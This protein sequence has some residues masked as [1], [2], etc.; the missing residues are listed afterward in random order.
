MP[1]TP[2]IDQTGVLPGTYVRLMVD[3]AREGVIVKPT[4]S[5]PQP[6]QDAGTCWFKQFELYRTPSLSLNDNDAGA[7]V[8]AA[9]KLTEF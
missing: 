8:T 7:Y 9:D 5:A 2:F 6:S 1:V 4:T 3:P